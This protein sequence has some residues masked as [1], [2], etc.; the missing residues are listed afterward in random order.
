MPKAA[1][2]ENGNAFFAKN[3][4]RLPWQWTVPAPAFDT[5]GAKD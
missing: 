4:V 5:V 2:H 1:I 3:E